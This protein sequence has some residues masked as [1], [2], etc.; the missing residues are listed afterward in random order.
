MINRFFHRIAFCSLFLLGSCMGDDPAS[1]DEVVVERSVTVSSGVW[2]LDGTESC[3][4]LFA[5]PCTS[6]FPDP[7]CASASPAG[8][9]CPS[10]GQWCYKTWTAGWFRAFQ[11]R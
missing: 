1:S 2:V 9:P 6:T 8:Q 5:R 4:D 3:N 10:I 7:Q 11:C